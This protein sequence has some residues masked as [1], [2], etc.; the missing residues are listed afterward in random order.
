MHGCWMAGAVQLEFDALDI[1]IPEVHAAL[2]MS[3]RASCASS[4]LSLDYDELLAEATCCSLGTSMALS[5]DAPFF[6]LR[7][8]Q[9]DGDGLRR[10]QDRASASAGGPLETL[11]ASGASAASTSR[12]Q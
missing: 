7:F 6:V 1:G 2:V 5:S 9:R 12:L 11:I 3:K 8:R 4:S 10:R